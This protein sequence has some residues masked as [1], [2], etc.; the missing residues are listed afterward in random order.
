M[1]R[2]H[3][4]KKYNAESTEAPSTRTFLKS[5]VG[6]AHEFETAAKANEQDEDDKDDTAGKVVK[7]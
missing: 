2:K 1:L 5:A 7:L 4:P 6:E 3:L